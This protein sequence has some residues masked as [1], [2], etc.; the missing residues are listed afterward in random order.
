MLFGKVAASIKARVGCQVWACLKLVTI[1]AAERH[2]L[3]CRAS[4]WQ[5]VA[6]PQPV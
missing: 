2:L 4:M 1:G 6:C 3:H 5:V